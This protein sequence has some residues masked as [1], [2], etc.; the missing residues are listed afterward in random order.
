[1]M[2]EGLAQHVSKEDEIL[3]PELRTCLSRGDRNNKIVYEV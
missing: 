1:M 3:G 2:P